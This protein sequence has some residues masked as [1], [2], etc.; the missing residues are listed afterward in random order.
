MSEWQP[1][2]TAPRDG[3]DILTWDGELCAV[4]YWCRCSSQWSLNS[5]NC[6]DWTGVTHW[7]PLPSAPTKKPTPPREGDAP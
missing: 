2:Q 1:I 3:S 6:R 7:Q 5:D 4:C